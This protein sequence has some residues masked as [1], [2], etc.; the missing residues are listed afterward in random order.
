MMAARDITLIIALIASCY[1][2]VLGVVAYT[3]KQ[4]S[5][6]LYKYGLV[7]GCGITLVG[8]LVAIGAAYIKF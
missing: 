1:G 4:E 3:Y 2:M 8:F 5:P 6:K 7:T